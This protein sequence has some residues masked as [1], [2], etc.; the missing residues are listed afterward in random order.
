MS[1]MKAMALTARLCTVFA[2]VLTAAP[3]PGQTPPPFPL[4]RPA[5]GAPPRDAVGPAPGGTA[6]IRGRVVQ[7][8]ATTP[9]RRAMVTL[10]G[11]QNLTR[12][13]TTDADGRYEI[14]ELPAGRFNLTVTKGGYVSTSYG[15]RRPFETPR[16]VVL[17]AGQVLERIDIGLPQGGVIVGRVLDRSGEP[18]VGADIGV[19]RYQYAPDGQRKLTRVAVSAVVDDRGAFRVF[20]LPP[21]EYVVNANIRQRPSLP[22]TASAGAPVVAN[23]LT[24]FPGTP[25]A[26]EAGV[27]VLGIGEEAPVQFSMV[28]G[29]LGAVS[30]TVL[31]SSGRTGAGAEIALATTSAGGQWSSRGVGAAGADGT[32]TIPRVPPGEHLVQVRLAPRPGGVAEQEV[33]T[34]PIAA[35]GTNIEGLQVTTAPAVAVSGIVEWDGSASRAGGPTAFRIAGTP[36]DGR[37]PINFLG[38]TDTL[39][40]GIV[41]TD[42][43]FRLGGLTGTVRLTMTGV[44][45]L[46]TVKAIH[47]GRDEVTNTT[48]EAASLAGTTVRVVLTDKVTEVTGTVRDAAGATATEFVVVVLPEQPLDGP[49]ASRF[50]RL[51]RA[52]QKG[53][54]QVRG[55]PA[56]RYV[57]TAVPGLQPGSEWDPS[58]QATA[59]NEGRRFTL[60]DGQSLALAVELMP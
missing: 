50:T 46:W 7:A 11:E 34:V 27:I 39:A 28:S 53:A 18:A 56:G 14:S 33:A 17:A 3:A 21:G 57:I 41:G 29:R 35:N 19:E 44:P 54:F 45:P 31:D 24:Y 51:V 16:P 25:N 47:A 1:R 49:A 20:G 36:A 52:D 40:T 13:V 26:A 4:P 12:I 48:V 38:A 2:V 23:L 59:R 55:L 60:E 37:P 10:S 6:R 15:Q 8:G 5:P 22:G 32:F 43:A 9:I 58:F 42:D 30:G